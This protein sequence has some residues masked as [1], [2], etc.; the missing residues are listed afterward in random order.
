MNASL[1][2]AGKFDEKEAHNLAAKVAKMHK[3]GTLA[4]TVTPG[5]LAGNTPKMHTAKKS[6]TVTPT[7]TQRAT[8]QL[9]TDERKGATNNEI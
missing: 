7:S 4:R 5:P 9:V 1:T 2:H 8:D 6:T 3:G